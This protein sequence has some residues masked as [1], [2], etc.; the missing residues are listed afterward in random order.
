[1]KSMLF[2]TFIDVSAYGVRCLSAYLQQYGRIADI[3][4]LRLSDNRKSLLSKRP[5]GE[6]PAAFFNVL[7]AFIEKYD[8]IGLS[9]F[10][11]SFIECAIVSSEIKKNF[12][13]KIVIWGGI[14][15]TLKPFEC[16]KYADYICVGEGFYA[17]RDFLS[18]LDMKKDLDIQ[19]LPK[20]IWSKHSN[21]AV[22]N[23]C[24]DMCLDLDS[25]PFPNYD[26]KS[27]YVRNDDNS[28]SPLERAHYRKYLDYVYYTMFSLGCPNSCSYCCN[29]ALKQLNKNYF[30]IRKHSANYIMNEIKEAKKHYEF[31]NVYFMDDSFILMDDKTFCEFVDRYPK[32]VGLPLIITG[33][34]PRFIT[35]KHI[36]RLI[37]AGM[38][39]GRVGVQSG[40]SRMLKIYNR[41][42]TNEEVLRVSKMFAKYKKKMV[43]LAYDFIL[44][45]YDEHIEDTIETAKLISQLA[46]PFLLNLASLRAYPGTEISKYMAEYCQG[47]SC[48]HL[49]NT[50]INALIGLMSVIR[51]P[52]FFLNKILKQKKLLARRVPSFINTLIY[53]AIIC[54][55]TFYHLKYGDY[56][57]KPV[58]LVNIIRRLKFQEFWSCQK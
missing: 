16:L 19:D 39:R 18:K 36:D 25:L 2:I 58:W 46:R 20:G 35:E 38:I 55:K 26:A 3:L 17:L 28:I 15:P 6:I 37:E 11:D 9:L 1:M 56:S 4:C 24:S 5:S 32:E 50:F 33:L 7:L 31:Y 41:K 51:I 45:G 34:I 27:V 21:F 14:H 12:P 47:D 54:K 8:I 10:S 40:S 30:K 42:Q 52:R 13:D 22:K 44:D 49:N 43:P 48:L 23:G 53:Y 29:N 57:S